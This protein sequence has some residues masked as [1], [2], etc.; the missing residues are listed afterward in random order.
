MMVQAKLA[1]IKGIPP[2]EWIIRFLF[3]G[4]VCVLAGLI[5]QKF[6]AEVGGL[7]LAFPAIFPAGASLVEAHERRHKARAGFDGTL[8][9]R[10]VAGLEAAGASIGCIALAGFAMVCWLCLP[11]ISTAAVFVLATASWFLI[12]MSLWWLRKSRIFRSRH[13]HRRPVH[14]FRTSR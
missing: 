1:A 6:G 12:A 10:T 9:G 14:A 11:R 5:S 8:R 7:F 2:H 3:G 4:A 13:A